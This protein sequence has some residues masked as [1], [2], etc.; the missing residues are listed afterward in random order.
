[1]TEEKKSSANQLAVERTELANERSD[2]ALDRTLMAAER[3]LMAWMRTGISQISFGFTIYKILQ[4]FVEEGTLKYH[5][6]TPPRVGLLLISLG[7]TAIIFGIIEYRHTLHHYK[8]KTKRQPVVMA[9]FIVLLG[10]TFVI[11]IILN[12]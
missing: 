11:A 5:N 4:G 10:L 6:M 9:G 12:W 1:V 3:T 7:V 2:M 8:V